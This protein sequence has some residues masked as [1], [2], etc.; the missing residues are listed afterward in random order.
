[1]IMG[2]D[3]GQKGG[4]AL[5]SDPDTILRVEA[6]P[7][8]N[9]EVQSGWLYALIDAFCPSQVI[10]ERQMIMSGQRGAM[11]IGSNFGRILAAIE[12]ASVPYTLVTPTSWNRRAGIPA[13]LKGKDKKEASFAAAR[14]TWG[15]Q[16]DRL[17]LRPTQDGQVE[18]LLIARY[19][20][21]S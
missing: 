4:V 1:M 17:G 11:A 9:K 8:L 10:V 6:M 5:L 19:G 14:R 12:I 15:R 3:P 18:A 13:K 20:L 2:I 16:F 7:I 21:D